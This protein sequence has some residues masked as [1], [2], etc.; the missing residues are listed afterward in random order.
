M[1]YVMQITYSAYFAYM[2][3]SIRRIVKAYEKT[4]KD[5]NVVP[6]QYLQKSYGAVCVHEA[7]RRGWGGA[8]V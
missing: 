5:T 1:I 6:R 3:C 7:G 8:S 4:N 2:F